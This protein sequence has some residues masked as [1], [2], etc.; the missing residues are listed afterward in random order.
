MNKKSFLTIILVSI[1]CLAFLSV[2]SA[3]ARSP[4]QYR[5][6]GVAIGVG[7]AIIGSALLHPPYYHRPSPP[8]FYHHPPYYPRPDCDSWEVRREWVPPQ[9]DW[10]W[11]PDHYDHRGCWVP[12]YWEKRLIYPGRWEERRYRLCDR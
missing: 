1:T 11:I 9:Y 10:V 2:S 8:P 5:W 6:E 7:A 4:Q 12:G 3:Y